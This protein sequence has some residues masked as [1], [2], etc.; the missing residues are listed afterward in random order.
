MKQ[1]NPQR[2]SIMTGIVRAIKPIHK[3]YKYR[4]P[5]KSTIRTD[6]NKYSTIDQIRAL[7]IP[8]GFKHD[9]RALNKE[10]NN[11]RFIHT[12]RFFTMLCGV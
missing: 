1:S 2:L 8:N 11:K 7:P 5:K 3:T 10:K 4:M 12:G 9:V 6:T